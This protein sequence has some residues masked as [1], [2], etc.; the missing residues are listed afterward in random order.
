M[1]KKE[2]KWPTHVDIGGMPFKIVYTIPNRKKRVLYL[3]GRELY[4]SCNLFT[5]TIHIDKRHPRL[6]P[7]VLFHEIVHA[8]VTHADMDEVAGDESLVKPFTHMLFNAMKQLKM[9]AD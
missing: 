8:C 4:G 5:H 3:G 1:K 9:I 6:I 7:F 2:R